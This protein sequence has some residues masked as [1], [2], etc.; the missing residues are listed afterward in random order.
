MMH[1][2]SQYLTPQKI[3]KK[4]WLVTALLM[5][6][7]MINFADKAVLGLVAESAMAELQMTSTEFGFIGSSFFFLFAISG[8]V[9][10]FAAGK[11]QTKWIILVMGVSWAILQFPMLFGGGAMALLVTR[12]ILGAAEGPASSISLQHVQGWF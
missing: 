1:K 6:F 3:L 4:A 12:V 9:V 5:I 2:T 10:G 7:Q 8:V 11:I